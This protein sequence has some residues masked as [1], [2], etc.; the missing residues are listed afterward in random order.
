MLLEF[1]QEVFLKLWE[2]LA[3]LESSINI[4]SFLFKICI[5][6]IYDSIRWKN[7]EQAYL[8]YPFKTN[9]SF[10]NYT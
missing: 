6:L 2:I 4:K 10:E 7:I 3:T 9:L 5:N 8:D 1:L